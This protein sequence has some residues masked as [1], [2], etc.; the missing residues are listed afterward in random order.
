MVLMRATI[1]R[2]LARYTLI[3]PQALF[4]SKDTRTDLK[5]FYRFFLGSSTALPEK[6]PLFCT[7]QPPALERLFA[8]LTQGLL[9]VELE[10]HSYRIGRHERRENPL[11]SQRFPRNL[12]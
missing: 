1:T 12:R 7:G 11:K 9:K 4:M 10:K 2:V 3:T 5:H 6:L 8:P